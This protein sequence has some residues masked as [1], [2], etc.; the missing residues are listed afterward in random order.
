M[1]LKRIRLLA[2]LAI[3][4]CSSCSLADLRTPELLS[5]GA[6]EPLEMRG[7]AILE[8]ALDASGGRSTWERVSAA[9][10][11]L[12]DEWQGC[13]GQ[14]FRPWPADPTALE[15]HYEFPMRAAWAEFLSEPVR[16][17]L[18]G[19]EGDRTW[20]ESKGRARVF[21]RR[22]SQRFIFAAYQYFFELPLRIIEAPIVLYAGKAERKGRRYDLVFATWGRL[23]PHKEHDQYLLWVA[24]DTHRIEIAQYTIRDKFSFATGVNYFSKFRLVDGLILPH[25]YWIARRLSDKDFVHR[26]VLS[27]ISL[28]RAEQPTPVH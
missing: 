19:R 11:R 23:E 9:K 17:E 16:G 7:R 20:I 24:Q 3:I 12:E 22:E 27:E 6:T 5:T 8:L 25:A 4:F 18:W 15:M 2:S 28:E 21:G 10:L 1:Q 14:L 26:V 13:I